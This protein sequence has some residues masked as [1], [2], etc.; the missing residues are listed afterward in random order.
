MNVKIEFIN[1]IDENTI[2]IIKLTKSKNGKTGTA[3]FLF[4][5]P[6][7]FNYI[8]LLNQDIEKLTLILN[9]TKIIT[10]DIEILFKNGTPFVIKA[11]FIFKNSKEWFNFLNFMN[12]Y[13][14]ETGLSFS[15]TKSSF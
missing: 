13:S 15:E 6:T 5:K 12:Q 11:I 14:K 3:T 9:Q 1:N 10:T 4:I 8:S 7:I 2:P